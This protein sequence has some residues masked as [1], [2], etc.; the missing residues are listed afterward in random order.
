M[1]MIIGIDPGSEESG[2]VVLEDY[3]II[4]AFNLTNDVQLYDKITNYSLSKDLTI[5]IEDIKP[6]S[7]RLTPQVIDTCKFIG[8]LVY[9]L[10]INAGLNVVMVS[11]Y[12]VKKW[13]FDT[14]PGVCLPI[15]D[16]KI[17]KKMFD[18]CDLKTREL[19]RVDCNGRSKRKASFVFVDDKVVTECMKYKY[20]IP[21]PKAGKG[22]DKGLQT[23][24][25]QALAVASYHLHTLH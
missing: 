3:S 10:R 17:E 13:C 15:I 4:V 12:E 19:I 2:M 6:Y 25:W 22:Y 7:L 14:F 9:R 21:L 20:K 5:V 16:S 24:S 11:R 18:A 8:E 23:H 1:C